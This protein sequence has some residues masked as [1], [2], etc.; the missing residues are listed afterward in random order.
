M[1]RSIYPSWTSSS[2]STWDSSEETYSEEYDT[3]DSDDD[4]SLGSVEVTD[5]PETN[6]LFKLVQEYYREQA[7]K[8]RPS[9]I[10]PDK[11]SK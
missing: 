1:K 5:I 11:P 10:V 9:A 3:D 6:P 2:D 8:G 4:S 7:M